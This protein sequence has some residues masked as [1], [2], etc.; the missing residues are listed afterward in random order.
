MTT[1]NEQELNDVVQDTTEPKDAEFNE[2]TAKRF[3]GSLTGNASTATQLQNN[4][5]VVFNGDVEG[6]LSDCNGAGGYV[7][8]IKVNE[9]NHAKSAEFTAK[10]NYSDHAHFADLANLATHSLTTDTAHNAEHSNES[11]EALHSVESDHALQSDKSLQ[12]DNASNAKESEHALNSDESL[13]AVQADTDSKERNIA[14]TFDGI[15]YTDLPTI[16]TDIANIT[17]TAHTVEFKDKNYKLRN[18]LLA[19]ENNENKLLQDF[20]NNIEDVDNR[21]TNLETTTDLGNVTLRLD[22]LEQKDI[23]LKSKIDSNTN[24]ISSNTTAIS[25]NATAISKNAT[26]ITELKQTVNNNK[27]ASDNQFSTINSDV[28]SL[29]STTANNTLRIEQNTSSITSLNSDVSK[30]RSDFETADTTINERVNSIES[31]LN[32]YQL[33]SDAVKTVNGINADSNGN[34]QLDTTSLITNQIIQSPVP[35]T[36]A[37]LH[38]LDGT[39][40]SGSG[41][42]ADYV[43]MMAELYNGGSASSSFCTEAEWQ[44]SNTNYGFCNKF[45][46]DSVANTVRLPKVNSEHGALIKSYSNGSDWYRIY[47]DGWIEQGGLASCVYTGTEVTIPIPFKD[48]NYTVNCTDTRYGGATF[49]V[50]AEVLS[51]STVKMCSGFTAATPTHWHACGYTDISDLQNV[52]IYEYIVVGTLSKTDIQINIDNVMSDL[53]GK[54]DKDLSNVTVNVITLKEEWHDNNGNFYRVYSD[55]WCEQGGITNYNNTDYT[56]SLLK[57]FKDTNFKIFFQPQ[58]PNSATSV[59]SSFDIIVKSKTKT[60]VSI[61]LYARQVNDPNTSLNWYACGYV[62]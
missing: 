5:S 22:A 56:L 42:Y 21:I 24:N 57:A 44:T 10:T 52:P 45:V 25:N 54:A 50:A 15:L 23:E 40:L 19:D 20:S 51:N 61:F 55:G 37:N 59:D 39:L 18:T 36:D 47:E 41:A 28:S 7:V 29:Q 12:A 16:R 9:S 53:N 14:D 17:P 8:N 38:L 49:N 30:V 31:N 2:V 26:D 6:R 58:K 11:D 46:Y 60:T 34:I 62:R 32:N 1:L 4:F 35:L 3:I 33:K 13:H 43:A 27:S 48:K